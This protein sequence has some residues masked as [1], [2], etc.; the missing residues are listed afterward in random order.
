MKVTRRG[1]GGEGVTEPRFS[2][3]LPLGHGLRCVLFHHL[4]TVDGP[5]TRGLGVSISPEAFERRLRFLM[6]HYEMIDLDAVLS[7]GSDP[8]RRPLLVTFDDAY[9]SVAR[10]AAPILERFGVPAVF[11]VNGA[12]VQGEHLPIDNLVCFVANTVG[13]DAVRAA[14]VEIGIPDGPVLS[15]VPEVIARVVSGLD[16][17]ELRA[18]G[19]ALRDRVPVDPLAEAHREG[20]FLTPAELEGLPERGV[21]VGNH[22]Y[23]HVWCRQLDAAAAELEIAH[24]AEVLEACTRRPVRAF[25]VPY[26][27][28]ADLTPTVVAAVEGSGHVATFLV[29]ARANR[30]PVDRGAIQRVSLRDASDA[31][32]AVDLEILPRLRRL[33]DRV[34]A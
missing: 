3:R 31:R 1:D 26:G 17:D 28:R 12:T 7:P 14:V 11:F 22:T 8:R 19:R 13:F 16:A 5:F 33:R 18:F 15:S 10:E 34:R 30:H 20:L 32:T 2:R 29:D 4:T 9:A 27:R 25:S 23:H 21:E 24:N 6:R